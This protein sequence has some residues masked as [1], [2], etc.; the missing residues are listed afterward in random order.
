M[1]LIKHLRTPWLLGAMIVATVVGEFLAWKICG[2]LGLR[3]PPVP[4]AALCVGA[5]AAFV[6][7]QYDGVD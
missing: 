1:K 2:V 5:V 3:F 4:V 7:W 6:A